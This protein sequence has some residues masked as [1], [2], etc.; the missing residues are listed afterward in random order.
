MKLQHMIIIF[1]VIMLP[2]SL[3]MSQYTSLQIDT[4]SAKTK[5]DTALL[6]ATFDTMSAFE[7]NTINSKASSVVGEEIRDLEAVIS[8]FATSLASSLGMTSASTDYILSRVPALVFGLYDG[9]YIYAQNDTGTG[10]ELKPYVYY[11]K[12]YSRDNTNITIAYSLDNYVSIYGKY[13]GKTISESG[14]LVITSDIEISPNFAYVIT[15]DEER[16]TTKKVIDP[17]TRAGGQKSWVR[18]KSKYDNTTYYDI[19]PETIYENET[20][21]GTDEMLIDKTRE[22]TEGMMYYYEAVQFTTLYNEV[23]STLSISDKNKLVISKDNDPEDEYS[24]FM[25]EKINVMKDSI[26]KNLNNAIYNYEGAVSDN[27][28]MPQLKGEDWEKILNNISI[29]AFL[30][31]IQ[32]GAMKY[33]NY[34]VVNSTTNQKYNSA[35]S[36]DFIEYVNDEHKGKTSYGYYHKI[37]CDELIKNIENRTISEIIGYASVDFKRYRYEQEDSNDYFYYYKHNE[38]ADYACE[39]ETIENQNVATIEAYIRAKTTDSNTRNKILKA[40]YTAVGR[41]RNSQVKASSYINLD[42]AKS[43]TVS[44]YPNG[45]SWSKGNPEKVTTTIGKL[46]TI[47]EIPTATEKLFMGWSTPNSTVVEVKVGDTIYGQE[48]TTIDLYAVWKQ[49]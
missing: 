7:L 3:I 4:L 36:I 6:S 22:T 16:G 46:S 2:L 19:G 17:G 29:T 18:I 23:V 41:I 35:K 47:S 49:K 33:N 42:K 20:L 8:T 32:I 26:T 48:G 1:L 43:F 21:S 31:D 14:Y 10:R 27:Y 30:K 9:Y 24:P 11:T 37:T 40:Y 38:Y 28:E 39:V 13:N 12:T 44:Y 25:D 34:A 45:G 15:A 5:C